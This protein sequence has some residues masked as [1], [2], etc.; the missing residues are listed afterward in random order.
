[1]FALT[2]K[3]AIVTGAS[4]GIGRATAKL[5]AEAGAKVV[6]AARRQAELDALVAEIEEADGTAIALAGDVRDEAYANALVDLAVD[7][8]GGLDIAFNNAGSV[9]QMG[10]VPDM[11]LATWHETIDINLTGAFIGAKYQVPALL[12]RGGGSLIF[13]SSFVGRTAGMPGMAAYAA[14]KAG[15]IGL[16]QVLAAEYGAQGLRVNALLPGGTDTPGATTTTPEARAF[17][18]GIHALKRMAQPEEIARSA[19]YLASDASSFTTGTALF[20]DGGVS[21]NRT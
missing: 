8:F 4:S 12:E 1:M 15:L 18:E 10:P 13:T 14:A 11:S 16:T 20:A 6:V 3:V 2:N 5:F 9:G 7:R 17:V 21:I 19:L